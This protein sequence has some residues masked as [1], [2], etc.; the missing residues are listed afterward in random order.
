MSIRPNVTRITVDYVGGQKVFNITDP[1]V[2]LPEA[3][4]FRDTGVTK[5]LPIFYV[6]ADTPTEMSKAEVEALWGSKIANAIFGASAQPT[7]TK[8][9]DKQFIETA[10]NT[11]DES[12][13]L[14]PLIAKKPRCP[15]E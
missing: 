14:L 4:F 10:W 3:I 13:N 1:D 5:I 12:G 8:I 7:D 11:Q 15:L 2:D 6:F 9:I